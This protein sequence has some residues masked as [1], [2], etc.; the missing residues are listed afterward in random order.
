M[1]TSTSMPSSFSEAYIVSMWIWLYLVS[2]LIV[3][4]TDVIARH[5]SRRS[6]TR[7][8]W[9]WYRTPTNMWLNCRPL[10]RTSARS[11]AKDFVPRQRRA[12]CFV[13]AVPFESNDAANR[14]RERNWKPS[15]TVPIFWPHRWF[16]YGRSNCSYARPIG[17]GI[18]GLFIRLLRVVC[19]GMHC[20]IHQLEE[21][22]L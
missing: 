17:D 14:T 3:I 8:S 1:T 16:W 7:Q 10:S 22:L 12:L 20:Q 9:W 5:A 2:F 18:S 19:G 4:L 11:L 6:L 15:L 13:I 21:N